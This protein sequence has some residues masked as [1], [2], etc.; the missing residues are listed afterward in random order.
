MINILFATTV[1]E[2]CSSEGAI[3]LEEVDLFDDTI[4]RLEVCYGGHWG[5]V[6]GDGA[7]D[8]TIAIVACRELNHASEGMDHSY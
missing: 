6:C 8:I 3:R 1:L 5:S 4:R 2:P 7:N